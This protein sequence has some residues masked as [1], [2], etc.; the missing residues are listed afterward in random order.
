M[1]ADANAVEKQTDRLV[2]ATKLLTAGGRIVPA[3]STLSSSRRTL[4][5]RRLTSA[6][7]RL[8]RRRDRG[9]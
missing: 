2:C 7:G 8:D 1:R 3:F 4:R 9:R 5:C 6:S